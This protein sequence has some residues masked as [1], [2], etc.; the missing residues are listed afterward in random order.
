MRD[1]A[2]LDSK[3]TSANMKCYCVLHYVSISGLYTALASFNYLT[4]TPEIN[5]FVRT[6]DGYDPK[7]TNKCK[8]LPAPV[9][10][11]WTLAS[12]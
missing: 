5:T 10:N 9:E 6:G 3:E 8:V 1:G 7:V 4:G 2:L 11:K 12:A